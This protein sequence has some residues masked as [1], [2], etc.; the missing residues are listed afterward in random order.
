MSG[1]A[2]REECHHETLRPVGCCYPAF[3]ARA[4]A[5]TGFSAFLAVSLGA[6]F[7]ASLA[8][9]ASLPPLPAIG[10]SISRWPSI[11]FFGFLPLALVAGGASFSVA[12]LFFSAS[13]KL[14]T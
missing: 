11:R 3:L 7:G 9:A 5:R 4:G 10:S 8:A 12:R 14:M 13:I 1:R 2:R 6:S